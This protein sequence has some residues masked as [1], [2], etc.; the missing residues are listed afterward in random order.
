MAHFN[1]D[2]YV[3]VAER[4]TQFWAQHPE[5][6]IETRLEHV[7]TDSRLFA[8]WAAVYKNA[9]D[10]KPWATGLAEE[11]F[12]QSGPNQTSPLEN[13]ESSA[14]GRALANAGYATT[15]EGRP[16]REEMQKVAYGSSNEAPRAYAPPPAP[17]AAGEKIDKSRNGVI[18]YFFNKDGKAADA[19]VATRFGVK[20]TQDL[21]IEQFN[22]MMGELNPN[23]VKGRTI[24]DVNAEASGAALVEQAFG[25]SEEPF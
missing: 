16:S 1:L 3:T 11:H 10:E 8:V 14:I 2:N 19:Y 23:K 25:M 6:R 9:S 17:P 21:T 12:G 24:D 5:G 20:R 7:S 15:A 4:I 18:W 13:C 22:E